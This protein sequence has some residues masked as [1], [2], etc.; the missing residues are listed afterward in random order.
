MIGYSTT[1]VGVSGLPIR[2]NTRG[3]VV[4]MTLRREASAAAD[5]RIGENCI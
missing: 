4:V 5:S 3:E 1:G 2:F